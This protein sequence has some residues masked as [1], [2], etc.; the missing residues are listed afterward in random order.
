[1]PRRNEKGKGSQKVLV[2]DHGKGS[3]GRGGQPQNT[4]R[5]D[6]VAERGDKVGRTSG[7]VWL[8]ESLSW[9][10]R[11]DPSHVCHTGQEGPRCDTSAVCRQP[12]QSMALVGIP[13]WIQQARRLEHVRTRQIVVVTAVAMAKASA[14]HALP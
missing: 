10:Q 1:M 14:E 2:S 8:W 3:A 13:P 11:T 9:A 12:R 7:P 4:N 5:S 6:N